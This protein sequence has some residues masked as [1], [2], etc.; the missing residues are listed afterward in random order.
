MSLRHPRPSPKA[1]PQGAV[2][3]GY[4]MAG[5]RGEPL[6]RS[7]FTPIM[8]VR[9]WPGRE[10]GSAGRLTWLRSGLY[11]VTLVGDCLFGGDG[12][13]RANEFGVRRLTELGLVATLD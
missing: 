7:P 10:I 6:C 3:I 2:R 9:S 11:S 4:K 13:E 8:I 12:A 5:R 1:C